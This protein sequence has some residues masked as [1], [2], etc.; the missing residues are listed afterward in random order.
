MANKL[1]CA[2]HASSPSNV[3]RG[4]GGARGARGGRGRRGG[5]RGRRGNSGGTVAR[6]AQPARVAA[7]LKTELKLVGSQAREDID[8]EDVD[9]DFNEDVFNHNSEE[10]D[11]DEHD[12]LDADDDND[13]DGDPDLGAPAS[14]LDESSQADVPTELIAPDPLM[15]V[16]RH[17]LVVMRG[18]L[19]ALATCAAKSQITATPK[20][21]SLLQMGDSIYWFA[22]EPSQTPP[23]LEGRIVTLD[24]T[25]KPRYTAPGAKRINVL[26]VAPGI[27][28]GVNRFLLHTGLEHIKSVDMRDPIGDH[29]LLVDRLWHN[30]LCADAHEEVRCWGCGTNKRPCPMCMTSLSDE[31]CV[32]ASIVPHL[33]MMSALERV[34]GRDVSICTVAP[35]MLLPEMRR[36]DLCSCCSYWFSERDRI[37]TEG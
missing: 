15:R 7:T 37:I 21:I 30:I 25:T 14:P 23:K 31:C 18:V 11:E 12:S 27:A 20:Y 10:E 26:N 2:K 5:G 17:W 34:V 29:N 35:T 8:V 36:G 13:D 9:A 24:R 19:N 3:P 1:R 33:D 4:S 32:E 22:L 28:A 6:R 16:F